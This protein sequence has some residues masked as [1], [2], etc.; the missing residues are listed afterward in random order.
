MKGVL[1][2]V[3]IKKILFSVFIVVILQAPDV[4]AM[5]QVTGDSVVKADYDTATGFY[6]GIK[7]NKLRLLL[8]EQG[9]LRYYTIPPGFPMLKELQNMPHK[10]PIQ[11]KAR[12]GNVLEVLVLGGQP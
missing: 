1:E 7:N 8:S 9:G 5:K 11:V 6:G 3:T 2:M 10:T 12:N 4:I